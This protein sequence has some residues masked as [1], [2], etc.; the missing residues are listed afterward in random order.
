MTRLIHRILLQSL[1]ACLLKWR[2][3]SSALCCRMCASASPRP[4]LGVCWWF[5]RAPARHSVGEMGR[6]PTCPK[7]W[8]Q[9]QTAT[10]TK[11]WNISRAAIGN[12][13]SAA[14][15]IMIWWPKSRR[16]APTSRAALPLTLT[17]RWM[18]CCACL[19]RPFRRRD[20]LLPSPHSMPGC[21]PGRPRV[22]LIS[23]WKT[24]AVGV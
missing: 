9:Q 14:S 21:C 13:G 16:S 3:R 24:A 23:S 11:P 19:I 4:S 2:G 8:R 12:S 10:G 20:Y 17:W 18:H 6:F 15:I 7:T 22:K 5:H 1:T